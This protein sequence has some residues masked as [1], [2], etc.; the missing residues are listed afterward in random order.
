[1]TNKTNQDEWEEI[2]GSSTNSKTWDFTTNPEFIGY[3]VGVQ[4]NVGKNASNLYSFR[5]ESGEMVSIWG[6]ALLDNRLVSLEVGEKVKIVY[7]GKERN[8]KSGREYKNFQIFHS[9]AKH[10]ENR[11]DDV[12]VINEDE[13]NAELEKAGEKEV[14]F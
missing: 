2:S 10:K 6:S 8:P 13:V 1:M 11:M 3:Y 5:Q 12:P 9:T 7:Q 4:S 14:P